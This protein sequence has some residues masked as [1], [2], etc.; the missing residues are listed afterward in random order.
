MN[1]KITIKRN[2]LA[3]III[4]VIAFFFWYSTNLQNAFYQ[5]I[6]FLEHYT[7]KHLIIGSFIFLGLAALSA[8]ISPLSSIPLVP[9]AILIFGKGLTFALLLLGWLIGGVIAYLIGKYAGYPFV[10]KFVPFKQFDRSIQ[11]L[12]KR[13]AFWLA[14][15]FR[16]STPSETGYLFGILRYPFGKYFLIT[17]L[18]ELPIVLVSIIASEALIAKK[19]FLFISMIAAGFL[20]IT[21]LFYF[22]RKH[23]RTMK[24]KTQ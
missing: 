18:S 9:A 23:L 4:L 5:V 22:V 8:F 13:S 14:L 15:L 11:N 16:I 17:F 3:L 20:I 24:K 2:L 10:K 21:L 19:T 6:E 1:K 12:P 7:N